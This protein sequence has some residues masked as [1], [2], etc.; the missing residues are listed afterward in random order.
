IRPHANPA[1]ELFE[2]GISSFE[3]DCNKINIG[4]FGNFYEN[5]GIGPIIEALESMPVEYRQ[6]FDLHVF[7]N[8]V[9][10]IERMKKERSLGAS[11]IAHTYLPYLD[12]LATLN[13]FDVLLVN[14]VDM[15]GSKFEV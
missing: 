13:E 11:V 8:N 10:L 2:I 9:E 4:Y 3:P 5:R 1:A 6:K 7:C 12:F 15:G 14:D